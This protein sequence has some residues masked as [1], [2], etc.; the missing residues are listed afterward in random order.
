[1]DALVIRHLM[2]TSPEVVTVS[3]GNAHKRRYRREMTTR[4]DT[5]KPRQARR[6]LAQDVSK[7]L[8][9][10]AGMAS[11]VL[12]DVC[13]RYSTIGGVAVAPSAAAAAPFVRLQSQFS[14]DNNI[15]AATFQRFRMLL[16]TKCGRASPL[17][18]R[19]DLMRAAVEEHNQA[20]AKGQGTLLFSQRAALEA[21]IFDLRRQGQFLERA[22]RGAN[23]RELVA[24][25][26][27]EGQKTATIPPASCVTDVH[28]IFGLDKGGLISS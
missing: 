11:A 17:E 18:L 23:G 5:G 26:A 6:R 15:S 20:T 19:M 10:D 1:V 25:R 12:E 8:W 16:G 22:V 27:F 2:A 13:R 14:V 4:K 7:I 9:V 21:L 3:L 24:S 28:I